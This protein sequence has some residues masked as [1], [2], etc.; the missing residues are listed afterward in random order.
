MG[1]TIRTVDRVA[2]MMVGV[3][4]ISLVGRAVVVSRPASRSRSF[5]SW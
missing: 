2:V 5:V 4:A 3:L 1:A